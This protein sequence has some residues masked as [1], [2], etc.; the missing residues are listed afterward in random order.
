MI[1]AVDIGGTKIGVGIVDSDGCMLW[2]VQSPTAPDKGY[3]NALDRIVNMLRDACTSPA[4]R[5]TGIGIG[6][7]GPIYPLTGEIGNVNFFPN[8]QGENPVRDLERIFK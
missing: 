4:T 3:A 1:A 6:S 8:W 2:Q 7:T 5:I